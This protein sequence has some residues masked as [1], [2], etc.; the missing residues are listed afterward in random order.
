MKKQKKDY[1]IP[2]Y[3]QI[4]LLNVNDKIKENVSTYLRQAKG[5]IESKDKVPFVF[6]IGKDC[7]SIKNQLKKFGI[8]IKTK[9]I[10]EC[11][12]SLYYMEYL[13]THQ[14]IGYCAKQYENTIYRLGR[15]IS[16]N[17]IK[18]INNKNEN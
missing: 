9:E 2:E 8:K 13:Y 16:V 18:Y 11:E 5:I 3:F 12:T 10:K 4:T 15:L 17:V 6:F 14:E 1:L 7:L